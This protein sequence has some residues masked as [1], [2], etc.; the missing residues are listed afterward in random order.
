MSKRV[1]GLLLVAVIAMAIIPGVTQAKMPKINVKKIYR[2]Y[3]YYMEH[4]TW[5]VFAYREIT[6][7]YAL[8]GARAFRADDYRQAKEKRIEKGVHVPGDF[9]GVIRDIPLKGRVLL[10][11]THGEAVQYFFTAIDG[12]TTREKMRELEYG[13]IIRRLAI[14][15][16]LREVLIGKSPGSILLREGYEL[17]YLDRGKLTED[18]LKRFDLLVVTTP[19]KDFGLDEIAAI[20]KYVEEGG[21]LLLIGEAKNL[22]RSNERLNPVAERFGF[23]LNEDVVLNKERS[24]PSEMEKVYLHRDTINTE[25]VGEEVVLVL[26]DGGSSIS[27]LDGQTVATSDENAYTDEGFTADPEEAPYWFNDYPPVIARTTFGKGKVVVAGDVD[28]L[29]ENY[30][31]SKVLDNRAL[32][33]GL[34]EWLTKK[35]QPPE[36]GE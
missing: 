6:P 31:V 36:T 2:G 33:L 35:E 32:V 19:T 10:D 7:D 22:W 26:Y 14:R 27:L 3:E 21:S 15:R 8:Y 28:L 34:V 12:Q 1:I 4:P 5:S 23:H 17:S 16:M 13:H 18:L 24:V 20:E 30:L 9:S 25:L 11:G 29:R